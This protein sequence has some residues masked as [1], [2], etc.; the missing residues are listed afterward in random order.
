VH[1]NRVLQAF[2]REG[3]ITL[4]QRQL[5]LHDVGALQN[6]AGLTQNYLHLTGVPAETG[7][8]LDRLERR[9]TI[10]RGRAAGTC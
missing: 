4:I 3:L 7:R 5:R 10:N 8:Y 1:V 9:E 6:L 2:R